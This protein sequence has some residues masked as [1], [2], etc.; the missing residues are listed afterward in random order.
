MILKR[1]NM[2]AGI[3]GML[4]S[5][6]EGTPVVTGGVKPMCRAYGGGQVWIIM[7]D[8]KG[9]IYA[10]TAE[11]LRDG[12]SA[13]PRRVAQLD[14]EPMCMTGTS[15]NE[16]VIMTTDNRE[17]LDY[18]DG[19]WVYRGRLGKL[20]SVTI[21]ETDVSVSATIDSMDLSSIDLREGLS[22]K[23][24]RKVAKNIIP[25]VKRL[26]AIA[27]KGGG[28]VMPVRIRWLITDK[29][30]NIT[31]KSEPII[32]GGIP[33]GI[34]SMS[35][36][37]A[38]NGS[39]SGGTVTVSAKKITIT[40]GSSAEMSGRWSDHTG[41]LITEC[42]GEGEWD[43]TE[44][45]MEWRIERPSSGDAV[46]TVMFRAP[47]SDMS[48][49]AMTKRKEIDISATEERSI[50]L[51]AAKK[52][53]RAKNSSMAEILSEEPFTAAH[54]LKHGDV[55]IWAGIKSN[56][57]VMPGI[58]AAARSN[59]GLTV[60]DTADCGDPGIE[61]LAGAARKA[62]TWG[63]GCG[64]VYGMTRGGI[65]GIAVS[66][67]KRKLSVSMLTSGELHGDKLTT[68]ATSE[69][70]AIAINGGI[71]IAEIRGTGKRSIATRPEK[72]T[73]WLG[74]DPAH[75]ELYA[76]YEDGSSEVFELQN[77]KGGHTES[78]E[79]YRLTAEHVM[80]TEGMLLVTHNGTT[81]NLSKE[82]K[83][84]AADIE[85]IQEQPMAGSVNGIHIGISA[86]EFDG[87]IETGV[88]SGQDNYSPIATYR[89]RG[90][91]RSGIKLNTPLP[92]REK[93]RVTVKGAGR[94][95]TMANN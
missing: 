69:G 86:E 35:M 79:G 85:I 28:T 80:T 38:E 8:G 55:I 63:F 10:V 15:D 48:D 45:N 92:H 20:P 34:I 6:S 50:N 29:K 36:S 77:R 51:K 72:R 57:K 26:I 61:A 94:R 37:I 41:Q 64:H 31:G 83:D 75:D 47:E 93:M 67:T 78:H 2:R 42:S 25:T 40:V 68:A 58:I 1:K 18:T 11:D 62:S 12:L 46:M 90:A 21:A 59:Q 71:E 91:I 22:D 30:G 7:T 65:Y 16:L 76:G 9:G 56:G 33:G 54:G 84:K 88:C 3:D 53:E 23:E 5:V 4:H 14:E 89:V 44:D 19:A 66:G 39:V 82:R 95:L 43:I 27:R 17:F 60:T 24:R 52:Y 70:V 73:V 32:T 74:Y 13:M 81:T 49:A 87:T